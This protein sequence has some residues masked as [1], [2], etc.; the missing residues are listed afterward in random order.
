MHDE[1]PILV[2]A[3]EFMKHYRRMMNHKHTKRC[4]FTDW[5]GCQTRLRFQTKASNAESKLMKVIKQHA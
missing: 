5:S 4:V 3:A 1:H 2:A